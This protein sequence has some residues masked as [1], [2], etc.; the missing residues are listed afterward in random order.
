M[1][2]GLWLATS[3]TSNFMA[4]YL[5]NYSAWSFRQ[6][7]PFRSIVISSAVASYV[8]RFLRGENNA[9]LPVQAPTKY[10]T[11][12]NSK[13]RKRSDSPFLTCCWCAPTR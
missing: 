13:L 4:A 3:F 6:I 7:S 8:D 1:I 12:L 10:I 5:G 11:V 2:M 9:N